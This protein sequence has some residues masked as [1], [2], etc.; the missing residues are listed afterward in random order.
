ME[1]GDTAQQGTCNGSISGKMLENLLPVAYL[2]V[3]LYQIDKET[4]RLIK[5]QMTNRKGLFYFDELP[6][7]DYIVKGKLQDGDYISEEFTL[8]KRLNHC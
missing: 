2:P 1:L 5:T 4:E 3:F 6:N 7:G 8:R